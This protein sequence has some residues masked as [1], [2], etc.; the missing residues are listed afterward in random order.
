MGNPI[1]VFTTYAQNATHS[2]ATTNVAGHAGAYTNGTA[3]PA[4]TPFVELKSDLVPRSETFSNGDHTVSDF[5]TVRTHTSHNQQASFTNTYVVGTLTN[6]YYNIRST[7]GTFS[8]KGGQYE[9][10]SF[11]T[12]SASGSVSGN[13]SKSGVG[14]NY[15]AFANSGDGNGLTFSIVGTA[16]NTTYVVGPPTAYAP[17][18]PFSNIEFDVSDLNQEQKYMNAMIRDLRELN[19]RESK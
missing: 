19:K 3:N 10:L 17:N 6:T 12:G 5:D 9:L 11:D 13:I 18:K 1:V 7:L 16:A 4:N 15:I 2:H 8:L 14:H